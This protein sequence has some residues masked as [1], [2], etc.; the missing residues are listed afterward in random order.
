MYSILYKD[1]SLTKIKGIS[2]I[3]DKINFNKFKNNFY[4]QKTIDISDTQFRKN[5]INMKI[6]NSTKIIDFGC[7]NKRIF[8]ISK[9]RTYPVKINTLYNDNEN[10]NIR[11]VASIG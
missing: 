6:L 11:K 9:T 1:K 7:Y 10:K 8:N 2:K 3:N 4:T 5:F